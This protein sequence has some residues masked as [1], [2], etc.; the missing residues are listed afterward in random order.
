MNNTT[1]ATG[2]ISVGASSTTVTGVGTAWANSGVR[3]GDVLLAAGDIIPIASVNSNTSIT[4]K[5]P[6]S[7][8]ALSG[9]NYDILLLDDDVRSLV[10][11]N[12]LLQALKAGTLT[13]LA[14][15]AGGAN[16]LPYFTGT[17][18]MAQTDLSAFARTLLDDADATAFWTTIGATA[19]PAQ[20]FRRGNV[21]GTVS[22]AGSVPAGALIERG[23]NA[24]GE[25][26]RLADGTQICWHTAPAAYISGSTVRA[27]WSFPVAFVG[28]PSVFCAPSYLSAVGYAEASSDRYL[29][30]SA[31]AVSASTISTFLDL[32]RSFG[33]PAIPS[34]AT[35]NIFGL[36]V[37]R[38]V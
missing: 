8:A 10:A 29:W 26:V 32:Q 3:A 27:A 16:K 1:Y 33:A 6:W 35:I 21:I 5:R 2:T 19:T 31:G 17:G 30:G 4:L 37:G 24:N 36:A 13:S 18:V 34:G 12:E 7:G 23:N 14:G 38:W 15:L 25:Y 28:A 22:R 20:A 9:A 11:A